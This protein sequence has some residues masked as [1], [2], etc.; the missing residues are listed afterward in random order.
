MSD[1]KRIAEDVPYSQRTP[2]DWAI[3][4]FHNADARHKRALAEVE[5]ARQERY[6]TESAVLTTAEMERKT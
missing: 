1:E 4:A 2:L 6:E 5:A 3:I